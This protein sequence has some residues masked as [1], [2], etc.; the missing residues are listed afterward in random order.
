MKNS[1]YPEIEPKGNISLRIFSM[2]S[3]SVTLP[4]QKNRKIL[5]DVL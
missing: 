5:M 1:R 4:S 2:D 3:G